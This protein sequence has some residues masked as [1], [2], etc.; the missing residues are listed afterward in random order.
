MI[1]PDSPACYARSREGKTYLLFLQRDRLMAQPFDAGTA[2]VSGEPAFIAEPLQSV[3]SFSA[4]ENGVLIFRR[5]LGSRAQLTWFDREGKP[6]GTA[7][8]A[9]GIFTPRISP[10]QPLHVWP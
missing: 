2:A 1:N 5:G 10:D 3:P 7:G 6:L 8:D 9:G 4:S